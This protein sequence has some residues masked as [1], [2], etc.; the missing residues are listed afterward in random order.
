MDDD[1]EDYRPASSSHYSA[2]SLRVVEMT[3]SEDGR[4]KKKR[5]SHFVEVPSQEEVT[6]S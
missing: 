5:R 2:P 1:V 6:T 4:T 3:S